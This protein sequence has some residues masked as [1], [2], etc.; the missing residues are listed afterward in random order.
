MNIHTKTSSKYNNHS[1]IP[2][3][4]RICKKMIAMNTLCNNT[5]IDTKSCTKYRNSNMDEEP[6]AVEEE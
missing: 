6:S 3:Y 4:N 2:N 5:H 1:S